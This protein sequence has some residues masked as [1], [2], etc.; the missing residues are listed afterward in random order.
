MVGGG[1][2]VT[3]FDVRPAARELL[4]RMS[5]TPEALVVLGSGL[6]QMAGELEGASSV[7]F[8]Q[9]PGFPAAAV[10]G[11]DGRYAAGWLEGRYV[12]VQAGRFHL[13]EGY[14]PD[15]VVAP[16]RLAH[17]VGVRTVLLTNAAGGVDPSLEPG[18][19]V[20]IE[21]HLNLTGVN[22]LVGPVRQGEPRFPDMTRAY[23]PALLAALERAAGALGLRLSRGVY[24]AVLGPSFET[25]AEVRALRRAGADLVGMSTVPEV[26]MARSLGLRCA[27]VSLV[28][29]RAAGAGQE[30]LTH[31]EVLE[32]GRRGGDRLWSL[33]RAVVR[34]LPE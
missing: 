14:A 13:Y 5:G 26:I 21:D 9:L 6:S 27:A 33:L 3:D 18:D 30:P 10:P 32:A 31:D 17:R 20:A 8:A 2:A 24:A 11:H 25:P 15:L 22:P 7:P 4:A 16:L 1:D 12:L 28:T 34:D 29:N 19:L 23:D